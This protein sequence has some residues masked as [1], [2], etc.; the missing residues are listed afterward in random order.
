[1]L[2]FIKNISTTEFLI[3][4]AVLLV[5]FGSRVVTNMARGAGETLKE[6]KKIKKSFNEALEDESPRESQKEVA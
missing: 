6:V 2:N 3:V 5:L 1:M 4:A